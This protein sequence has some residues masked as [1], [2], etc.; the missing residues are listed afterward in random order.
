MSGLGG[1]EGKTALL[2]RA[3]LEAP[4]LVASLWFCSNTLPS[5]EIS[6]RLCLP[7]VSDIGS[8]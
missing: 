7:L 1:S 4:Q 3:W 6:D 5:L 8:Y 2:E